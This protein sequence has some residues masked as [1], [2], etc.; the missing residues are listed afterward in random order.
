MFADR[1]PSCGRIS[2]TTAHIAVCSE[3]H[4]IVTQ[5]NK[6]VEQLESW[7]DD[8]QTDSILVEMICSYL[9]AGGGS[10]MLSLIHPKWPRKYTILTKYQDKLRWQHFVEG[11]VV[12]LFIEYQRQYLHAFILSTL[13]ILL[14]TNGF[15]ASSN[16]SSTSHIG[17]GS[18]TMLKFTLGVPMG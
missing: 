5:Y 4:H 7:L 18:S 1:C 13:N 10:T 6:S 2:E 8:N 17:T 9:E 15:Q 3:A 14:L 16:S 11:R 12:S